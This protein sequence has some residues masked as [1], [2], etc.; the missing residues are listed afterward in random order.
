MPKDRNGILGTIIFHNLVILILI[1]FGFTRPIE[2][3][4]SGDIVINF[5]NESSG[6]GITEPAET[7]EANEVTQPSVPPS[8]AITV[9]DA[10]EDIQVQDYQKAP[11][12][13]PK[14]TEKKQNIKK[15]SE[16][17]AEVEKKEEKP[18]QAD[19]RALYTGKSKSQSSE[20]SEGTGGQTGNQGSPEGSVDSD[21][22]ALGTGGISFDLEGRGSVSLPKPELNYQ[23]QG[24]V[25]VEIT[26]D[27][28][29][30]VT[31]VNPGVKGSTTLDTYLLNAARS[32]ALKSKFTARP[33]APFHQKGYITYHFK[34]QSGNF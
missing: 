25:V 22:Y 15:V 28:Q 3:M 19:K 18:R 8:Q 14:K 20:S 4:G 16:A 30:N 27:R 5:G 9:E 33:D 6:S 32:A 11:A 10:S 34:L 24:I 17:P 13:A 7:P 1:F 31:N 2:P 26:V 21:S 12:V 23:K 29:G